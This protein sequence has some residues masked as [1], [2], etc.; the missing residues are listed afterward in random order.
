[1]NHSRSNVMLRCAKI[2]DPIIRRMIINTQDDNKHLT[3]IFTSL[4]CHFFLI[5]LLFQTIPYKMFEFFIIEAKNFVCLMNNVT[6]SILS[7]SFL[8]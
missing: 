7:F 1:M 3:L 2:N 4:F 5:T 8:S 6:F